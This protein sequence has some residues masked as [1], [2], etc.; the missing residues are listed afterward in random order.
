MKFF[1]TL[2]G[3]LFTGTIVAVFNTAALAEFPD[4]VERMFVTKDC[5]VLNNN[6]LQTFQNFVFFFTRILQNFGKFRK[7]QGP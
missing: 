7:Y 5:R 2:R 1:E 4:A 6:F 3:L